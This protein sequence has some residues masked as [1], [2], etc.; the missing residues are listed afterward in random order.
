MVL[1]SGILLGKQNTVELLIKFPTRERTEKFFKYLDQYYKLLSGKHAYHFLITCDSNDST[2]N[3]KKVKKKFE[4]YENLTVIYGENF[5]K[6]Y[7][8]NRDMDKAPEFDVVM[9]ASDDMWPHT[10]DYDDIILNKMQ[11]HFPDLNGVLN[12]ADGHPKGSHILNTYPILGRKYFDSYR[13]I[14]HPIYKSYFCDLDLAL[15]S[16]L[17]GKE[18]ILD[19][20]ILTHN[21]PV[22]TNEKDKLFLFN[23][24][25]YW[26]D[27]KKCVARF[28]SHFELKN[29]TED[30]YKYLD[31]CKHKLEEEQ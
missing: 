31:F 17:Q 14:Y 21:N 29:L 20:E 2:M 1:F 3:N 22:F 30:Q 10:Q 23:H 9:L 7:A 25:L 6:I 28:A 12:C 5:S 16:R 13:Y 27:Q 19:I 18:A 8:C 26:I 4:G 24:R 15:V 11:E